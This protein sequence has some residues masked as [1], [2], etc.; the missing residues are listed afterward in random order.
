M[1]HAFLIGLNMGLGATA[2]L[3]A[4]AADK[5]EAQIKLFQYKPKELTVKAGTMVTWTNGDQIEHSVTAGGPGKQ[6]GAFDSDFFT[7]DGSWSFTFTEPGT[8]SYFC[9]RHNSMTATITVTP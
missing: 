1:K 5:V 3:P 2:A 4:L 7:K 8:Y 9:K 6:T